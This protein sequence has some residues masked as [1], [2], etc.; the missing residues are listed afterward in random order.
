MVA[1]EQKVSLDGKIALVAKL[2]ASDKEMRKTNNDL[3]ARMETATASLQ[4]MTKAIIP[5]QK[6]AA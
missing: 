1:E 5:L 3:Q 2:S 4:E 6:V